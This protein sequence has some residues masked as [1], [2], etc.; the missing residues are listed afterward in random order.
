MQV[1][2]LI[3]KGIVFLCITKQTERQ[4]LPFA[5]LLRVRDTFSEQPSL[6]S[7]SYRAG[8]DEFDRDFK[9]VL[10]QILVSS[11]NLWSVHF[12]CILLNLLEDV[13]LF[14]IG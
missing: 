4:Y 1:H 6:I 5:F 10:V 12:H 9:P 14:I 11:K 3:D 7:R 8:E 2:V 13:F